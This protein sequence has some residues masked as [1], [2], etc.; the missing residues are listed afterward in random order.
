MPS[1]PLAFVTSRDVRRNR[2]YS[3]VQRSC[4]GQ[5]FG[6]TSIDWKSMGDRGGRELLKL[7]TK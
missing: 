1:G 7:L 2:T 5:E 6:S 3:S 4:S